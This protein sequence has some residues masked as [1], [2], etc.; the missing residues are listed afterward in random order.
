[1][2]AQN[3]KT[4]TIKIRPIELDQF[5]LM[6]RDLF[7]S[8]S[9]FLDITNKIS[10][11]TD[12]YETD[13]GIKVEIAAVGLGKEDLSIIT[14]SDILRIKY[15]KKEDTQDKKSIIYSG[16]KKSSFDLAWK[17]ASK[18]DLAN[19]EAKMQNGLLSIDIPFADSKKPNVLTIK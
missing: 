4:M 5:D 18:F 6:W 7:N 15:N 13:T 17:I 2:G 19:A 1:M 14:D 11:P 9:H 10:H 3:L 12:I 8:T 16:I